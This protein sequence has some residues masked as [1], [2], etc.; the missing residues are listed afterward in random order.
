MEC[1]LHREPWT[2]DGPESNLFGLEP[3]FGCCTANF[4][5]GWP[6]FAASLFM[7]SQDDGLV[8][9]AYAPCEV[10][11]VVRDTPVH[12]VEETNYPFRGTVRMRVNPASPLAFPLLLRIPAW[13]AGTRIKINGQAAARAGAGHLCAHRENME[14]QGIASMS[15]FRL[16]RE[17]RSGSRTRSPWSA[18]HWSSLMGS[19]KTG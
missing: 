1:S 8:A 10:R 7:L 11:T 5:Q 3:N 19:A 2:T 4:H 6:K 14:G 13:A 9:A 17:C 16:S 12:V 18:G 15:S